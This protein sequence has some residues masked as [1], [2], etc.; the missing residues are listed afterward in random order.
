M[1]PVFNQILQ[2]TKINNSQIFVNLNPARQSINYGWHHEWA[3]DAESELFHQQL[4][5]IIE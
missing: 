4:E 5:K 3:E 2:I 1:D